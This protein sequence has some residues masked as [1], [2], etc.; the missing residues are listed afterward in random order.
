MLPQSL[1]AFLLFFACSYLHEFIYM[2]CLQG[3]NVHVAT[4]LQLEANITELNPKQSINKLFS[5]IFLKMRIFLS[6]LK[7]YLVI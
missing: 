7:T 5:C 1:P 4:S 3:L 6:L 2:N